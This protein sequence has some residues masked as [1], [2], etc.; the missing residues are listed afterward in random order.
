VPGDAPALDRFGRSA[1]RGKVG[2]CRVPSAGRCSTPRPAN[3]DPWTGNQVGYVGAASW[4]AVVPTTAEHPQAAWDF[5]AHWPP[6]DSQQTVMD[7]VRG[8][9][10]SREGHLDQPPLER[11]RSQRRTDAED[12]RSARQ[13]L[14]RAGRTPVVRLRI[15][16]ERAHSTP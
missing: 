7:P 9:G 6:E 13:T 8:G 16:E 12:A 10:A 4:L 3:G 11:L 1:V 2:V 15:L 14:G 5:L